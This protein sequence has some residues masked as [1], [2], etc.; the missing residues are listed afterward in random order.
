MTLAFDLLTFKW[1]STLCL[2]CGNCNSILRLQAQTWQT[3]RYDPELWLRDFEMASAI[4]CAVGNLYTKFELSLLFSWWSWVMCQV[5]TQTCDMIT[6][7]YLLLTFQLRIFSTREVSLGYYLHQVFNIALPLIRQVRY[8]LCLNIMTAG[9]L[10]GAERHLPTIR[11]LDFWLIGLKLA[12][13]IKMSPGTFL[14]NSN[15]TQLSLLDW[16]RLDVA[17]ERTDRQCSIENVRTV[18]S[19]W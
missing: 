14:P 11:D 1:H 13:P 16:H 3:K 7:R 15:F 6:L 2:S 17:D 4:I 9:D 18:R 19:C 10:G 5:G 12:W 8:I